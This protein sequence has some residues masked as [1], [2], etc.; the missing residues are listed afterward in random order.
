MASGGTQ[1]GGNT[2][3]VGGTVAV[4]KALAQIGVPVPAPLNVLLTGEKTDWD[5]RLVLREAPAFAI[6]GEEV[7]LSLRIDDEGAALIDIERYTLSEEPFGHWR[8]A[9]SHDDQIRT[10]CGSI[11]QRERG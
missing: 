11:A 10:R 1:P 6:L 3:V 5:R 4:H 8:T 9:D 7:Q 2:L